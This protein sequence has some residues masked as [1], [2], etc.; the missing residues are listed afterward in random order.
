M[1]RKSDL[2]Q[3]VDPRP[4]EH[5]NP[6]AET[7]VSELPTNEEMKLIGG[8]DRNGRLIKGQVFLWKDGQHWKDL[9]DVRGEIT[10]G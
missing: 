8:I 9:W 3:G 7:T 6:K 4:V 2:K 5:D 10:P 1:V